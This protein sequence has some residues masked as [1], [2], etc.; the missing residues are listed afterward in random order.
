MDTAKHKMI[1]YLVL[2]IICLPCFIRAQEAVSTG[3]YLDLKYKYKFK[4]PANYIEKKISDE[5]VNLR[6]KKDIESTVRV[7]VNVMHYETVATTG[8][9][10]DFSKFVRAHPFS[11]YRQGAPEKAD[12]LMIKDYSSGKGLK[13]K[14]IYVRLISNMQQGGQGKEEQVIKGPVYIFDISSQ[15]GIPG[16]ALVI[17]QVADDSKTSRAIRGIVEELM[18]DN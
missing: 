11:L 8:K 13:G 4:M 5:K 10:Y 3:I 1:S 15:T 14:E 2:A 16:T 9:M 18:F 6:E 17:H 7:A 12:S